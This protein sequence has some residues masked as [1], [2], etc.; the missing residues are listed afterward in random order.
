MSYSEGQRKVNFLR[1]YIGESSPQPRHGAEDVVPRRSFRPSIRKLSPRSRLHLQQIQNPRQ[2]NKLLNLLCL[3]FLRR[4]I[5]QAL[6]YVTKKDTQHQ[7]FF[8]NCVYRDVAE[9]ITQIILYRINFV[10]ARGIRKSN[11]YSQLS[12]TV[13]KV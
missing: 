3:R 1:P 12:F 10:R 9:V 2:S 5:F 6:C 4:A 8:R 7:F 11:T 13:E